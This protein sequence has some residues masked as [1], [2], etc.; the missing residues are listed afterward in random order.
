MRTAAA[1]GWV[2][3]LL[4]LL[5]TIGWVASAKPLVQPLANE[6]TM[7][8]ATAISFVAAG[9]ALALIATGND[10][11]RL[12]SGLISAAHIVALGA[13]A[14]LGWFGGEQADAIK[15][16]GPDVPSWGTVVAFLLVSYAGF[17]SA[18]GHPAAARCG[19]AVLMIATSAVIGYLID[20]EW[21]YFYIEKSS[22]AMAIHTAVGFAALG[23]G[24]LLIAR[25]R[26]VVE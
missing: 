24:Y 25:G 7:K 16:V 14:T 10:F 13:S 1:I 5:V 6:V 22:T 23:C 18:I 12:V 3:A 15:S 2:T 17:M 19:W 26:H 11:D 21:M 8:P 9:I 4:G 20:V